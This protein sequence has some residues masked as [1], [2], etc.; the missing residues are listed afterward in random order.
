MNQGQAVTSMLGPPRGHHVSHI[1]DPAGRCL[2]GHMVP[3]AVNHHCS[4]EWPFQHWAILCGLLVL[5][6]QVRP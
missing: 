6:K 4:T 1:P 5:H 2:L 3:G